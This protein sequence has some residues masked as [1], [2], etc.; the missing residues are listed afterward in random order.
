MPQA[1]QAGKA[2]NQVIKNNIHT[3]FRG[4]T[5][6][7]GNQKECK[8]IHVQQHDVRAHDLDYKHV[9][10]KKLCTHGARVCLFYTT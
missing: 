7:H 2:A 6:G 9:Y 10:S 4:P 3:R 1:S 5:P 8:N